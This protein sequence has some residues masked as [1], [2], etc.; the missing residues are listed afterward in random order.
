MSLERIRGAARAFST[1]RV[2][3]AALLGLTRDAAPRPG[4]LVLA[5]VDRVGYTRR[6]HG[7]DG[8]R[9]SLFVG[10]EVVVAYAN[11]YAP[12]HFEAVVPADLGRCQLA[13]CGGVAGR[14]RLR[15]ERTR[16]ASDLV[17]VGL[18]TG[19]RGEV[20]N[21]A[22]FALA[23]VAAAGERPT[24]LVVA[25]TSMGSGK[26]TCAANLA[27]GLLHAGLRVGFAKVTG[28]AAAGDPWALQDAGAAPVLDFTD[29][30]HASTYLLPPREVESV[31]EAL[32]GHLAEARVD[33]AIVE[34]ADG[35]L[36]RETQA[37][38]AS[39]RL[40]RRTDA[41]LFA[42]ADAMGAVFGVERLRAA[43]HRV[44]AVS[45]V[46]TS[47]PLQTREVEEHAGA[48]VVRTRD[49]ADPATARKL[50]RG[51]RAADA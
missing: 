21:L 3:D 19:I 4:D 25:G 8:R 46:L 40:A 10:D 7:V 48:Y 31:L 12:R 2:P 24:T 49:L 51:A 27:R 34:L 13:A 5:R 37:L 18:L 16:A 30:G 42:G 35:L 38:L 11:R 20:V 1:R 43:G 32:H 36:Q 23:P 45:G 22:D 29:A 15:H 6:L 41:F 9:R 50:L 44:V 17:P 47:A 26:T 14:V 39:D 33:V 28:T